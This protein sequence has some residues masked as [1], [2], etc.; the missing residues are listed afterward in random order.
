MLEHGSEPGDGVR[1]GHA[2]RLAHSAALG[3]R[4]QLL[5]L[6]A[7][8]REMEMPRPPVA[9]AHLDLDKP[10]DHQPAQNAVH[11]L[12][13][14]SENCDQAADR[15]ARVAVDEVDRA[16]VGAPV[17]VLPEDPVGVGRESPVGEEHGLD[18]AP[19]LLVRQEQ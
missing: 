7:L 6:R 17:V 11:R 18:P 19:E 10:V 3:V 12:L 16:V 15:R 13:R 14:H 2:V 8:V 1:P 4:Q 5:K 9:R